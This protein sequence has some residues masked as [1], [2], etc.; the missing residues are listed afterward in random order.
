MKQHLSI[1]ISKPCSE[2][3][4]TFEKTGHGGFCNSCE[5]E[6][7]D[8]RKMTNNQV[9]HFVQ[10]SEDNVCG[11]FKT[12]QLNRIMETSKPIQQTKFKFLR[13]A[14]IAMLSLTS[15][16]HIQA[17]DKKP[18]TEVVQKAENKVQDKFLAGVVTDESGPL[19]GANIILKGT[20]IGTTTDFDGKFKFP[21]VLNEGDVLIVSYIG[22]K[23][24]KIVIKK[25]QKILK[26]ALTG[27]DIYLMGEV[28]VN[29][30]YKSKRD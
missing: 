7:I 10:N 27:D 5:K 16:H 21:R 20:K 1:S 18:V 29:Q 15:L 28:E 9:L 17:Q 24:Q 25:D 26:V 3:F 19:A 6:V 14:A 2:K 11:N 8:F 23:P 4:S 30:V 13:I 22:Y 12:S